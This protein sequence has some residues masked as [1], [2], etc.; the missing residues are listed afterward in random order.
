MD[1]PHR[2]AA[3]HDAGGVG[4]NLRPQRRT[5]ASSPFDGLVTLPE[6]TKLV[7]KNADHLRYH[8]SQPPPDAIAAIRTQLLGAGFNDRHD[9]NATSIAMARDGDEVL[10]SARDRYDGAE[11]ILVYRRRGE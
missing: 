5:N 8:T 4:I 9:A 7:S 10:G 1:P 3:G 2:V 6:G 11:V